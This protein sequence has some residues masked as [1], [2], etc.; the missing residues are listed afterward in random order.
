MIFIVLFFSQLDSAL[1]YL[2]EGIYENKLEALLKAESIC[3]GLSRAEKNCTLYYYLAEIDYRISNYYLQADKKEE[4]VQYLNSGIEWAQRS[5]KSNKDYSNGYAVLGALLGQ[6]ISLDENPLAGMLYGP[7]SKNKLEKAIKLN[8]QNAYA[9][10]RMG[11]SHLF[12]PKKWGGGVEKAIVS[13]LKA[14]E[15]LPQNAEYYVWLG[16]AYKKNGQSDLAVKQFEKA[17]QIKPSYGWAQ[18]ELN[19]IS[20]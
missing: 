13:F 20:R 14:I 1:Y 12:T 4:A 10:F 9:H 16:L 3:V 18:I 6:K 7:Q 19:L 2:D 8:P 5:I 15:L 11:V 17:L